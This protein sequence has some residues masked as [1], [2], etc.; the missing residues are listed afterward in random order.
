MQD[1]SIRA[2]IAAELPQ[3]LRGQLKRFQAG[4]KQPDPGFIKWVDAESIHLTFKFL[5]NIDAKSVES[6]G[7][8]LDNAVR[9]T[10]PFN[11]MTGRTGCFPN[12]KNARVYWLGLDGDTKRL[13]E[14][15]KRVDVAMSKLGFAVENRPFSAHL[16][17]AR[18]RE[19][20]T[21]INRSKLM[22]LI[23]AAE[24]KPVYEFKVDKIF[25]IRSRLTP[26]GAVYSH[27]AEITLNSSQDI[28]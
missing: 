8:V 20:N 3:E 26:Q 5:G 19:S 11:L 4:L 24:F 1:G 13:L 7:E 14:F 6:I 25:L 28:D 21:D 10:M 27:L 2:F 9:Q 22:G 23:Q 12:M 16:T 18:L 17:L 15:Q